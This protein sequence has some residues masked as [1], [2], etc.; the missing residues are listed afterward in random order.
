M[1]RSDFSALSSD[2]ARIKFLYQSLYQRGPSAE[3]VALGLDFLSQEPSKD[4][5]VSAASAPVKNPRRP[6]L[7]AMPANRPNAKRGGA[8]ATVSRAPLNAWQEY[9]HALFQANEFSFVN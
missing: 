3:E 6:G 7:A 1:S 2:E 4:R 5:V 8:T 9:A